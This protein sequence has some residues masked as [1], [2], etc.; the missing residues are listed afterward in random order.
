MSDISSEAEKLYHDVMEYIDDARE[1]TERG[2]FIAL[3]KLDER[4]KK[5]C[6]TIQGLK[7]E[8]SMGY[9]ESLASMMDELNDLQVLY[10]SKK[11]ALAREISDVGKHKQA[12]MAYKQQEVTANLSVVEPESDESAL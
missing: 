2:E 9:R 10:E 1:M 12:V 7:I 4:V 8:E 11:T 3:E 5:L 6:V